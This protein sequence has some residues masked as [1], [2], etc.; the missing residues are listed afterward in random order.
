LIWK[1]KRRR[2]CSSGTFYRFIIDDT[3]NCGLFE[4]IQP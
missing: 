3:D 2:R 1:E 4:K